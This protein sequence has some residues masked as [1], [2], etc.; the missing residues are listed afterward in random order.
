MLLLLILQLS[1]LVL[2][3]IILLV[4]QLLS[5]LKFI[6]NI[7][8]HINNIIK[9]LYIGVS[10]RYFLSV[11]HTGK[12]T[13]RNTHAIFLIGAVTLCSYDKNGMCVSRDLFLLLAR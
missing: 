6:L 1:I 2:L 7:I 10:P 8:I 12:E 9:L 11:S 4:F 13:P 3:Q 5:C